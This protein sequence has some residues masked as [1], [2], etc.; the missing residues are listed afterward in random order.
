MGLGFG[1][2]AF[3]ADSEL[4]GEEEDAVSET[5][6]WLEDLAQPASATANDNRD[7]IPAKSERFID[8]SVSHVLF[9]KILRFV[10]K[11]N[12]VTGVDERPAPAVAP[13]KRDYASS[14]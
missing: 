13:R 6:D 11:S 8:S 14:L 3:L 9:L 12:E 1:A 4:D 7:N 10:P 2:A 5:G